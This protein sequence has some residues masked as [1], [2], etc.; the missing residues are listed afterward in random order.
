M[1]EETNGNGVRITTRD[2]YFEVQRQGKILER[3][4][5][6][7]PDTDDKV[8]DHET[9]IRKLEMRMGWAVGV[10]GFLAALMPWIVSVLG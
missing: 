4:A 2:I 10:F 1:S 8:E 6:S 9:R 3:I 7:L 5:N